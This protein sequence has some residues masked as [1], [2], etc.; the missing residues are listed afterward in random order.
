V[1]EVLKRKGHDVIGLARDEKAVAVLASRDIEPVR[2]DL[3][4][5][6]MLAAQAARAGA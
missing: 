3:A 4:D 1:A 6:R 5:S 2:G